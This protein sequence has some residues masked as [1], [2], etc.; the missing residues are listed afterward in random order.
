SQLDKSADTVTALGSDTPRTL[1]EHLATLPDAKITATGTTTPR[2]LAERFSDMAIS[3]LDE[4]GVADGSLTDGSGTSN[5]AALQACFDLAESR[6]AS[7]GEGIPVIDIPPGVW[8]I[9]E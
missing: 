8:L 6:G 2:S 9:D 3:L 4:G 1:A 7:T 5:S